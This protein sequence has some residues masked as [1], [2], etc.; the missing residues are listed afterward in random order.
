MYFIECRSLTWTPDTD[1]PEWLR[2]DRYW[3][4]KITAL[5]TKALRREVKA[6]A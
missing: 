1:T 5:P 6:M 2:G 3:W 4:T